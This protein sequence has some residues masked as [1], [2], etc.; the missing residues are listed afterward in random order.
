MVK[1]L[2][3]S[4]ELDIK[5]SDG[6][7]H[8]TLGNNVVRIGDLDL[9]LIKVKFSGKYPSSPLASTFSRSAL[10]SLSVAGFPLD[11][12]QKLAI[13]SGDLVAYTNVGLDQ[14]YQLF[15]R[16]RTSPGMSGGGVFLA[17]GTLVGVHGRGEYDK[18]RSIAFDETTKTGVNIGIPLTHYLEFQGVAHERPAA[19]DSDEKASLLVAQGV[20]AMQEESGYQLAIKL[21]SQIT[22][23]DERQEAL[24]LRAVANYVLG[25]YQRS[26]SDLFKVAKLDPNSYD[27]WSNIGLSYAAVGELSLARTAFERSF[28]LIVAG[29]DKPE[30]NSQASAVINNLAL[31]VDQL[32]DDDKAS[33]YYSLAIEISP[34]NA[35]AI[36]NKGALLMNQRKYLQAVS[37]FDRAIQIQPGYANAYMNRGLLKELLGD[38]EAAISDLNKAIELD[39]VYPQ[40]YF[41]RARF[42]SRRGQKARALSDI[43]KVVALDPENPARF[44]E[45]ALFKHHINDLQGALIDLEKVIVF[46][47]RLADAFFERSVIY[48]KLGFTRDELFDLDRA[49]A[50]DPA[51]AKALRNR[52]MIRL[53]QKSYQLALGDLEAAIRSEPDNALGYKKLG[54]VYLE[55]NNRPKACS[56][57]RK[58]LDH[59]VADQDFSNLVSRICQ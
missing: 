38:P 40:A 5:T 48:R 1:G 19:V 6:I 7:R 46:E 22:D 18:R 11:N 32:G 9:A 44:W 50:S 52:A 3:P 27:N 51:H 34:T 54:A 55:M 57:F 25:N 24:E 49:I 10:A 56:A 33:E 45:R 26:R 28:R 20:L 4:E 21:L 59:E 15:Y 37:L 31:V 23:I 13:N 47:Y 29:V 12:P 2:A 36:A 30:F 8:S 17:D 16:I 53:S 42:F 43:D 35:S 41:S 14:G 39:P 58:A